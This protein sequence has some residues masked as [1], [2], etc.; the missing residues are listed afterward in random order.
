MTVITRTSYD[1]NGQLRAPTRLQEIQAGHCAGAWTFESGYTHYQ[2]FT[3]S[4]QADLDAQL[5]EF[6]GYANQL[7]TFSVLDLQPTTYS[8]G[9]YLHYAMKVVYVVEDIED[10][11]Q[12][13][14]NSRAH[15]SRTQAA[16]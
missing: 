11:Q 1:H 8:V 2:R 12:R 7:D 6:F 13:M 3:G 9:N 10:Y 4:N 14:A 16:A 5:R 15:R